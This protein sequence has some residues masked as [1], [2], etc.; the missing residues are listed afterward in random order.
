MNCKDCL[1]YEVCKIHGMKVDEKNTFK[2]EL[3]CGCFKSKSDFKEEKHGE[4]IHREDGELAC[5]ICHKEALMDEIYY[6]SL[7]C[8]AC[9]AK[10]DADMKTEITDFIDANHRSHYWYGG[11]CARIEYKGYT[12]VIE[13][14][15]DVRAEYAPNGQYKADV[16]DKNRSGAFYNELGCFLANDEELYKAIGNGD[17]K[18]D[19]NNWW[20]VFLIDPQGNWHDLEYVLDS[21]YL[22]EAVDE[23]K[24]LFNA[25]IQY[26]E[27]ETE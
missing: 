17:L 6:Q 13:A 26:V 21:S 16:K 7:Y 3:A 22:D 5:S 11:E 23:V 14:N 25:L 10:M 24:S 19:D 2:K 15:G 12:A 27:K 9:G 20:E 8:P 1:H 4:W 18:F